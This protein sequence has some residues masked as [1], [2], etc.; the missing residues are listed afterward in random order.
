VTIIGKAMSL[1]GYRARFLGRGFRFCDHNQ[2]HG[3]GEVCRVGNLGKFSDFVTITS[4][5]AR[6]KLPSEDFYKSPG[7]TVTI[8]V[9]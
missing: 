3:T 9:L 8:T 4:L 1:R 6:A 2:S 5:M 7:K